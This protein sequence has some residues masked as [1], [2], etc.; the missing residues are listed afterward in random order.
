MPRI[1]SP[2]AAEIASPLRS[3]PSATR[4]SSASWPPPSRAASSPTTA[5]S[6]RDDH[7]R[8][9]RPFGDAERRGR[10][11]CR[12]DR[13]RDLVGVGCADGHECASATPNAGGLG[14][15]AVGDRQRV[16]ASAE[17]EAVDRELLP[18]HELLDEEAAAPRHARAPPR[19]P[20]RA[21]VGVATTESPRWPW[22]S[23]ALTTHGQPS[24]AAAS[25]ASSQRPARADTGL[26]HARLAKRSRWRS[27]DVGQ[28]APPRA[29]AGAAAR[30]GRRRAP[31][32]RPA[33]RS[34]ARSGRR[35]APPRRAGR[36]RARPRRRRSRGGRRSGSRARPGSRSTAITYRP[37][38]RAAASS[39]SCA[40]PAPRTRR[41]VRSGPENALP[42]SL[43]L[44]V[45]RDSALEP[46]VEGRA[47][48]PARQRERLLGRADVAVDLSGPLG[49]VLL[50]RRAACRARRAPG[51]RSRSRRC[52]FRWR[53]SAPR[54]RRVERRLDDRLDRLGVVVH[55]EPVARCVAVAVNR[56]RLV[57]SACVMK[58]GITFSGCCR[59]P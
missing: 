20:A 46:L 11:A 49:H 5:P 42:P 14:D 22:R 13:L 37:R 1:S 57:R 2:S 26:R 19:R 10:P 50:Q 36:S 6:S 12:V 47:R 7:L 28:H 33:S 53:R 31:R 48:A 29:S 3:T 41:R 23:G 8:V 35:R 30:A 34:R 43:I 25:R 17:R 15:G 16:E 9:R 27:F 40:G 18:G 45:P 55:E 54:P 21:P 52:R 24:S 51:R 4:Q 39:P 38:L 44:A 58:R 32:C 59:G 56:Q